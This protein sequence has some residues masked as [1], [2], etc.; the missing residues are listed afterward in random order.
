M[1]QA[2]DFAAEW[3]S[4][5]TS[6]QRVLFQIASG[7]KTSNDLRDRMSL[8]AAAWIWIL[9][10]TFQMCFSLILRDLI[11]WQP[12]RCLMRYLDRQS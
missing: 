7:A 11:S 1:L 9:R 12:A 10:L 4:V 8:E 5:I 3:G 2:S 6:V